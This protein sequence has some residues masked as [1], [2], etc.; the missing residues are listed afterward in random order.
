[1]IIPYSKIIGMSVFAVKNQSCVGIIVGV[2]LK[3]QDFAVHGFIVKTSVLPFISNKV[4]SATDVV[5]LTPEGLVVENDN[6]VSD[7]HDAVR[8]HQ[9]I[10]DGYTGIQQKVITESGKRIG[11][12]FDY[13]VSAPDL[14]ISRIYIRSLLSERIL[15]KAAI[16]SFKKGIIIIRDDYDLVPLK[17]SALAAEMA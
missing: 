13:L 4:I 16:K 6:I 9:A 1:M 17:K 2:V 12:V 3:K 5:D 10:H 14:S 7:L 15:P 8:L 11:R